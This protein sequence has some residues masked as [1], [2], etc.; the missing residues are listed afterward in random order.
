MY[1]AAHDDNDEALRKIKRERKN[2]LF[3]EV[4]DQCGEIYDDKILTIVFAKRF[5]GYKRADLLFNNMERFNRLVTGK[6]F[7]VQ[8]IWAGKPYPADYSAIAVFDK[9]VHLCKTYPNCAILVGYELKLSKMLKAGAD[10][11][12]NL[13]RITHEASGTS[14]MAAAMNGAV[15]VSTPDGWFPEFSRPDI[16]SFVVPCPDTTLSEH[17]QDSLDAESLMDILEKKVLPAYYN[18]PKEWTSMMKN[19]MTD[20]IPFFDSDRLARQ[21]YD[22]LY[23]QSGLSCEV[24]ATE[25]IPVFAN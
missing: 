19:G 16:N 23:S 17:E 25:K 20:A 11:W 9:I 5:T 14:G 1:L 22:Q 3:E 18:Q 12:L 21:Y 4:S 24:T 10:V 7:P 2:Y 15:N 8:I 13:P 6:D